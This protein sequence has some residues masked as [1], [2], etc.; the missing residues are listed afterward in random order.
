MARAP[1]AAVEAPVL[2]H[3]DLYARHLIADDERRLTGVI[4][5]G[6][7]HVGDRALDVA[8]AHAFLPPGARAAFRRAYGAI[9]P[10]TWA[11]AAARAVQHAALLARYAR[12]AG[13]EDLRREAALS[14][15]WAGAEG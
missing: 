3:G 8:I 11:R 7:V 5:W 10:G 14:L 6:D 12:H 15:R 2:V 9:A 4:D 1:A 13:D